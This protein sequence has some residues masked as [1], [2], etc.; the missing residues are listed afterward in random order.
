M[1]NSRSPIPQIDPS[2]RILHQSHLRAADR[3]ERALHSAVVLPLPSA[4][5]SSLAAHLPAHA[6]AVSPLPIAVSTHSRVA[7]A[8]AALASAD[9]SIARRSPLRALD[10]ASAASAGESLDAVTHSLA[11]LSPPPVPTALH[12]SAECEQARALSDCLVFHI[13]FVAKNLKFVSPDTF[14]PFRVRRKTRFSAS[15]S[16]DSSATRVPNLR[17]WPH[18]FGR[19]RGTARSISCP[20]AATRMPWR[21]SHSQRRLPRSCINLAAMAV[22]AAAT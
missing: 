14:H 22:S 17:T 10:A 18:Y 7:D 6:V 11:A 20:R 21:V 12:S 4:V 19:R 2:I 16:R 5:S 9:D 3:I 1:T 8:S 15:R 13:A